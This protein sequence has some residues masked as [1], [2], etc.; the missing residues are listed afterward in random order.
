MTSEE[1]KN[2][3]EI[4]IKRV[5]EGFVEAFRAKDLDGVMSM[6]APEVV[7]FDVVPPLQYVGA[8]AL[9]KRWEEVFSL[10]PGSIGYE[11]ADLS[12]AVGE[13]MAFTHYFTR[14]SATLSTGQKIG[15]WLRCTA[16]FRKIGGQWLL[17]HDQ[18]SAPIDVQTGKAVLDFKP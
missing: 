13:D 8:A 12:I 14:T 18:I 6:Y 17:V 4:E 3:D 9:R 2:N 15:N 16:C 1:N 11:I 5:I 7:T 10:L